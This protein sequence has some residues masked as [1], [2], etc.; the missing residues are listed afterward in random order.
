MYCKELNKTFDSLEDKFKEL[1]ANKNS[2]I[3]QKKAVMKCADGIGTHSLLGTKD[4]ALKANTPIT[5]D[6]TEL[7]VTAVINT[8]NLMDSHG[9]VH[10]PGIWKK[11]L[12]ENKSIMHL[13]EHQMKFDKIISDGADLEATTKTMTWK[14]LGYDYEGSTQALVFNSTVKANRNPYMFS[15]YKGAH[16][17][18]HSVGMRYVKME[19]A[20]NSKEDWAKEEKAVWDKYYDQIANKELAMSEGHF[21]AVTEAKVIEGSAVPLGSN[22]IT[23]TLHNNKE[24]EAVDNDVNTSIIEPSID[25]QKQLTNILKQIKL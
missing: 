3:S 24:I 12:K 1:I 22:H 17:N 25:T 21:W 2:I 23:P 9:D 8:T 19:L 7:K 15:Q 20:V 11:S 14:S 6:V 13:Q 18:N 10:F 5:E 4:T 16:V